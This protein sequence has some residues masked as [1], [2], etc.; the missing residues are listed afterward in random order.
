MQKTLAM[1][2]YKNIHITF[3]PSST[4]F[5]YTEKEANLYFLKRNTV[6]WYNQSIYLVPLEVMTF[7]KDK[8]VQMYFSH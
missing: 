8:Y 6:A 2:M 3:H 5:M 7:E 4:S 1:Q